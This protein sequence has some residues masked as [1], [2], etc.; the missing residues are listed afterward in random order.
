MS[1]TA[2]NQY[3]C[4]D[5][6]V[7]NKRQNV[8]LQSIIYQPEKKLIGTR[9]IL[10]LGKS[11]VFPTNPVFT[12]EWPFSLSFNSRTVFIW[13]VKFTLSLT[14]CNND[15][16]DMMSPNHFCFSFG[17]IFG[18]LWGSL[19][20]EDHL[21]SILGIIC[22]LGIICVTVQSLPP[23]PLLPFYYGSIEKYSFHFPCRNLLTLKH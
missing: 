8:F 4:H 20:V 12:F 3:A 2:E 19:V 17:I 11:R 5:L 18:R 15:K 13:E 6:S 23:T 1:I 7:W 21:W 9:S 22:G 14:C 16:I 10:A